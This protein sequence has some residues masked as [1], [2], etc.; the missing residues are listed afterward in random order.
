MLPARVMR[1]AGIDEDAEGFAE[2]RFARAIIADDYLQTFLEA[3][4]FI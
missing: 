1:I 2:C 4:G 3:E